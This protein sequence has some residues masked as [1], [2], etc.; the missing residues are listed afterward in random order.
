MSSLK[1]R[2][3]SCGASLLHVTKR[4]SLWVWL[5]VNV[6]PQLVQISAMQRVQLYAN[7]RRDW[8]RAG[9]NLIQIRL[10]PNANRTA[11]GSL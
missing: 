9:N 10:M 3:R 8:P 1:I 4:I 7:A 2:D 6:R 5:R 11:E